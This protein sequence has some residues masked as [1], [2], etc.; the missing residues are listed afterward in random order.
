[1]SWPLAKGHILPVKASLGA[2]M[3]S[4]FVRSAFLVF[5]LSAFASAQARS[6]GGRPSA[7][8]PSSIT[9]PQPVPATA[10]TS[11]SSTV[12]ISGTVVLDDGSELTEPAVIQTICQGRRHSETYTDGR[13]NFSFRFGDPT[14]GAT[15]AITDA[16]SSNVTDRSGLQSRQNLQECQL[17]AEL[18]G[19]SSQPTELSSRMGMTGSIDV[20]RIPLH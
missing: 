13:G 16:T 9:S 15:A 5:A 10:P 17:Q 8:F 19:F 18:A 14:Q 11:T 6:G 7:G 1:M 12:Y 2:A 3:K 4:P 20:G